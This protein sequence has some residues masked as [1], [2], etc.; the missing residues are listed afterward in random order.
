M[1]EYLSSGPG[2]A[3]R[4]HQLAVT[5]Q[6]V[7][8]GVTGRPYMLKVFGDQSDDLG[9]LALLDRFLETEDDRPVGWSLRVLEGL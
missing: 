7:L 9:G 8:G 6:E 3:H 5:L 2:P 1:Q 4:V